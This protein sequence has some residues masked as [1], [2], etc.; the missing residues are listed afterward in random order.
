MTRLLLPAALLLFGACSMGRHM[1]TRT[2]L[3]PCIFIRWQND[4]MIC[5]CR[6]WA[7]HEPADTASFYDPYFEQCKTQGRAVWIPKLITE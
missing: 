5:M 1:S 2:A 4:T 3:V 6:D 7:P